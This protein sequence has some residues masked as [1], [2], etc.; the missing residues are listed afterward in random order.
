VAGFSLRDAEGRESRSFIA[1]QEATIQV[2]ALFLER[3]EQPT[4]GILIRDHLGNDVFGTNTFQQQIPT[5]VFEMGESF[6]AA[7]RLPLDLGPGVYSLTV[8]LH[9]FETHVHD[10]FDWIDR[11][12][13]F[14]ILPPASGRFIGTAFLKPRISV[15]RKE[16]IRQAT[17]WSAAL[18]S[19]FA[20]PPPRKIDLSRAA[21]PWLLDGW[22]PV[23]PGQDGPFVWSR[24][25]CVFVVDLRGQHLELEVGTDPAAG[26]HGSAQT[27]VWLYDRK[28]GTFAVDPSVPWSV[29][30]VPIPAELA[31]QTGLVSLKVPGWRPAARG[32]GND[33]RLL[34]IR[35]RR[36][37]VV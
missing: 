31:Q 30:R 24:E 33:Q 13:V 36:F 17:D 15:D 16:P 11:L 14:R 5:G 37:E 4:V 12:V 26:H 19:I 27:E 7:F 3:I 21:R 2:R 34:G 32:L 29:L 9:T 6:E 22:Y 18:A 10:S 28:V 1:G 8:A 25:S 35:V 20:E 23:E